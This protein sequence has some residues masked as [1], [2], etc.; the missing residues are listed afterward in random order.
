MICYFA[1]F[2]LFYVSVLTSSSNLVNLYI[3]SISTKL[4]TLSLTLNV[5][6]KATLKDVLH[7]LVLIWYRQNWSVVLVQQEQTRTHMESTNKHAL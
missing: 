4:H 2:F 5:S 7:V 6:Q 3:F 1:L